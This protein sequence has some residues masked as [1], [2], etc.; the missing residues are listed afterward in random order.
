VSG[1]STANGA[2]LQLWDCL[3]GGQYNQQW[4]RVPIENQP[5]YYALRARHSSKC[6][7]DLGGS[8]QQGNQIGQWEC[9]W[10]GNQQ[11]ELNG[12]INP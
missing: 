9:V 2:L 8:M 3:G 4:T 7:D 12:V 11:W 10:N 5:P 6:M 1:A